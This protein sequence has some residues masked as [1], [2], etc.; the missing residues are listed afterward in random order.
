MLMDHPSGVGLGSFWKGFRE[1]TNYPNVM[2]LTDLNIIVYRA[3]SEPLQFFLELGFIGGLLALIIFFY[4]MSIAIKTIL[5]IEDTRHKILCLGLGAA[6]LASA[7]HS[8]VDF[9]LHKPSSA[10]Q[11]WLLAGLL[12]GFAADL[13]NQK[14]LL[15]IKIKKTLS[16][17]FL[18]CALIIAGFSTHLYS[19]YVPASMHHQKAMDAI[20]TDCTEAIDEI[21]KTLALSPYYF[22]EHTSRIDIYSNC[23]KD[24]K[25]ILPILN[26][27]LELDNANTKALIQRAYILLGTKNYPAAYKDFK[28]V[29]DLLPHRPYGHYGIAQTLVVM[30]NYKL[31]IVELKKVVEKHPDFTDAKNQLENFKN[32]LAKKIPEGQTKQ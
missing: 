20:Y 3:H 4:L 2:P 23:V 13:F 22:R 15:S 18:V 17:I 5:R 25:R 30:G 28:R 16:A 11:F 19:S 8:I 27:E 29:A 6:L 1:Y 14:R 10:L 9:P 12:I 7:L 32:Q 24:D 26:Q 21:E 31:G